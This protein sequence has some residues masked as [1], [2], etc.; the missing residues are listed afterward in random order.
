MED[1]PKEEDD[2][3]PYAER[4][5]PNG[6]NDLESMMH[7]IKGILG[8]GI[9]A[10]PEAF[11]NSGMILGFVGSIGNGLLCTYAIH[12][13]VNCLY[14]L[15]KK[16]RKPALTYSEAMK[17]GFADG[18]AWAKPRSGL[19]CKLADSF[20]IAYQ[21]RLVDTFL[22]TF[23]LQRFPLAFGTTCFAFTSVAIV[24]AVENNMKTPKH[25]GG[26]FGIYNRSLAIL[27][28]VYIAL[29]FLGYWKFGEDT[30]SSIALNLPPNAIL[31]QTV[32]L[33]YALAIYISF[34][35]NGLVPINLL[36]NS[37]LYKRLEDSSSQLAWEYLLRILLVTICLVFAATVPMLGLFVSLLGAITLSHLL[38]IFPGLLDLCTRYPNNYGRGKIYKYRSIFLICYGYIGLLT[39]V[40]VGFYEIALEF[41]NI[42]SK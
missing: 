28:T 2:Y 5:V 15:C 24:F 36:W 13:F 20:I 1:N 3:D 17:V 42:Y 6:T 21:R 14:M 11:K 4:N 8:T 12:V 30:K 34:G 23:G 37:Y 26:W 38:F 9:L 31:T 39:G 25:F 22:L 19:A 33:L 7:I 27:M 32:N 40:S 10:M 35:L 18:P 29:A 41:K 16:N